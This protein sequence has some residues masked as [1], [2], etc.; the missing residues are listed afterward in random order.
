MLLDKVPVPQRYERIRKHLLEARQLGL[1]GILDLLN[2]ISAC[3]IYGE[4]MYRE[5]IASVL[6]KVGSKEIELET[7]IPEIA[8]DEAELH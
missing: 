2:Y 1:S 8:Q 4:N 3:L 5:P 7:A 6:S